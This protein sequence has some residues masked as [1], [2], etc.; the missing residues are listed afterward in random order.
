MGVFKW[1]WGSVATRCLINAIVFGQFD[2]WDYES[3]G[4]PYYVAHHNFRDFA[5]NHIIFGAIA[6]YYLLLPALKHHDY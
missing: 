5:Y 4:Y 6:L 3:W 1:I 2:T